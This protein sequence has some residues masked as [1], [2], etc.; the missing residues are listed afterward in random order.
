[1]AVNSD[2]GGGFTVAGGPWAGVGVRLIYAATRVLLRTV[3]PAI[4]FEM[5]I[6]SRRAAAG[7]A[8]SPCAAC[9]CCPHSRPRRDV[10]TTTKLSV[11]EGTNVSPSAAHDAASLP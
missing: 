2:V 5:C 10:C 3:L 7:A 8:C 11:S 6:H 4:A 9:Y 1:M